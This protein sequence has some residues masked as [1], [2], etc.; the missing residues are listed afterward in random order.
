MLTTYLLIVLSSNRL[1]TIVHENLA[2]LWKYVRGL[3]A[4]SAEA[5]DVVQESLLVLTKKLSSVEV[6][7]ERSFLIG[8]AT[9]IARARWRKGQRYTELT[10]E[11]AS[12]SCPAQAQ[13]ASQGRD[14]LRSFVSSLSEKHQ[15]VFVLFEIQAFSVPEIATMLGLAEGT[16]SS[17]LRTS[18][19]KY[20]CY[21][22]RLASRNEVPTLIRHKEVPIETIV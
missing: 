16:V 5:D 4:C 1:H 8:C 7:K 20:R 13:L 19:E 21:I 14:L 10:Q 18:R 22:Q 12:T 6:G 3:G 11:L 9:R 2:F 15:H 17:R